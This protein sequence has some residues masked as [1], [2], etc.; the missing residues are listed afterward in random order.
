MVLGG[1]LSVY[2]F[3]LGSPSCILKCFIR[4][5][6]FNYLKS[7]SN[8]PVPLP[9]SVGL[10]AALYFLVLSLFSILL[11]L[12]EIRKEQGFAFG[13]FNVE[14]RTREYVQF[15]HQLIKLQ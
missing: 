9:H 1:M 13:Q 11:Y 10:F 2:F 15:P 3:F 14:R 4:M 5:C 6:L 7:S 12:L 8:F